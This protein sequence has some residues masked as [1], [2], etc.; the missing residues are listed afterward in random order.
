MKFPQKI[1]NRITIQ[2][3]PFLGIFP[4]EMKTLI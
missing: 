3:I 4:N 2:T 1:K